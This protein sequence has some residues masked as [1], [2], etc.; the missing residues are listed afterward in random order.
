MVEG[1]DEGEFE[2]VLVLLWFGGFYGNCWSV[3]VVLRGVQR[4]CGL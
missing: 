1:L 3:G 4:V 2:V